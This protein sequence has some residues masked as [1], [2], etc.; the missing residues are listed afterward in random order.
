MGNKKFQLINLT[1]HDI[2]IIYNDER[3]RVSASGIILRIPTIR[4]K[5]GEIS[6]VPLYRVQYLLPEQLPPKRE[7]T[8]YIVS[9]V[10][11][12]VLKAYGVERDDFVAPNDYIRDQDGRVIGAR[13][14]ITL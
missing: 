2:T 4:E 1:P 13:S 11:L 9:S 12:L 6:N 3:I 5:V 8:Y 14:F 10:V 7:N